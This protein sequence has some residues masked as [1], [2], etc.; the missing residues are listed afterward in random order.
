MRCKNNDCGSIDN[1]AL[2]LNVQFM[3]SIEALSTDFDT[4]SH[5]IV[6]IATW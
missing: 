3:D 6:Y 5:I 2:K 4:G 1:I